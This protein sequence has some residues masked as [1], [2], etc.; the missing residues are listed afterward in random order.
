MITNRSGLKG[1]VIVRLYDNERNL[2]H[3]EEIYNLITTAGD[4]YYAKRSAAGVLPA[5]P[6]DV[7]KVTGMKLGVGTTTPSKSGAGSALVNYKTGSNL[8]FLASFPQLQDLTGDTGWNVLYYAQWLPGVA[9]DTALTE[10]VIVNDS[11]A[12]A[13]STAA[14]TI[15]RVA[16][17][18][19]NKTAADTLE[20]S[21]AHTFL[22][23]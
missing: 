16:F 23:A 12:N 8:A 3:Y 10:A 9:T 4:E 13:T 17:S 15:S 5:A 11:A 19:I 20:I 2:K 7:T 6:S 14:N 1:V 21:W 18:A 22:G